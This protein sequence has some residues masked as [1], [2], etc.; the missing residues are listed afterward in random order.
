VV[1]RAQPLEV[2]ERGGPAPREGNAVVAL[3]AR[4]GVATL[5]HTAAVAHGQRPPLLDIDVARGAR[6]RLDVDT[7]GHDQAEVGIV[8]PGPHNRH[9]QRPDARDLARLARDRVAPHERVVV[10]EHVDHGTCRLALRARA[11]R[12]AHQGLERVHG[13]RGTRLAS[14]LAASRPEHAIDLGVEGRQQPCSR[15]GRRAELSAERAL[16]V[17]PGAQASVASD[18]FVT[19]PLVGGRVTHPTALVAQLLHRAVRPREQPRL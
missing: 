16:A 1:E 4:V 8:R 17:G 11:R 15:V 2:V 3:Q 9:R 7:V 18:R 12:R 6:H 5:D 13:I 10:D 14:T 19:R